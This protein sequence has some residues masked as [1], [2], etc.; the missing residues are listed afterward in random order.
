KQPVRLRESMLQL[1]SFASRPELAETGTAALECAKAIGRRSFTRIAN[2]SRR[3]SRVK[4][5]YRN[6][7][8]QFRYAM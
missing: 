2:G 4:T 8:K 7:N 3:P 1:R 6:G 5:S